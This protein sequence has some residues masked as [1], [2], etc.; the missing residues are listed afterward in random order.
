MLDMFS[1]PSLFQGIMSIALLGTTALHVY[2]R[3]SVNRFSSAV[4]ANGHDLSRS[5]FI[6]YCPV[7]STGAP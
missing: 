4:V 5:C 1:A 3:F 2:I 6:L 7:V